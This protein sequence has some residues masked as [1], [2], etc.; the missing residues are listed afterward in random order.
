MPKIHFLQYSELL[1]FI[2]MTTTIVISLN[3][4]HLISIECF[5]NCN[6]VGPY[7]AFLDRLSFPSSPPASVGRKT[8]A[9]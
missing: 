4:M 9:F 5:W 8:L 2:N 3:A 7:G 6:Q 1:S